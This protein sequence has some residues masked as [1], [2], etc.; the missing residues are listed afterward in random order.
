MTAL[1]LAASL[2]NRLREPEPLS[3][4]Q[5]WL[6]QSLARGA[7]GTALVHIERAYDGSGTWR[8][9][10]NWVKA[11]TGAD[12]HAADTAGLY[13]GAPA[14]SF[15]LHAAGADGVQRYEQVLTRLDAHIINL[16]HRRVDAAL[17]RIARRDPSSFAEYDL[18]T[19]LTGI[20][21]LLLEYAPQSEALARVLDYL[22]RL[23]RSLKTNDGV[24]PGWWVAHAPDPLLPTPGGHANVGLAHGVS[25]PLALLGTALRHG[26][27]VDGQIDAI[28]RSASTWTPGVRKTLPDPGGRSGSR[29]PIPGP[30]GHRRLTRSGRHG[31]TAHRA[32]LAPSRSPRSPSMTSRANSRPRQP[33]PRVWLTPTNWRG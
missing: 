3:T 16:T 33:C 15:L 1:D 11:A 17:D 10:H 30:A 27:S 23:T 26:I 28:E 13:N 4:D 32:S 18:F 25:G 8:T 24:L 29:S 19:G 12:I 22:V 7:A 5:P 14:I 20:G 31:A 21:L 2:A 6:A 9:A